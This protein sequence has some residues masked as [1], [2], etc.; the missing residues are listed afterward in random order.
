LSMSSMPKKMTSKK[1]IEIEIESE[2]Q[3][4]QILKGVTR[5][6]RCSVNQQIWSRISPN[7]NLLSKSNKINLFRRNNQINYCFSLQA[8]HIR[9]SVTPESMVGLFLL[10]IKSFRGKTG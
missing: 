9:V 3:I 1:K 5:F 10:W 4:F 8:R 7:L 2:I 6:K